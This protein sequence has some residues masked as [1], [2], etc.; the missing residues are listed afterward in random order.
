MKV[1]CNLRKA[2]A[3]Q[4]QISITIFLLVIHMSLVNCY[5]WKITT[6]L[7]MGKSTNYQ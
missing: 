5:I 2:K 6:M 4:D 3:K 7:F 1:L